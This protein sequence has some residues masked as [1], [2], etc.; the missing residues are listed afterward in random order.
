MIKLQQNPTKEGVNRK[1]NHKKIT[2]L[3]KL[4]VPEVQVVWSTPSE[5]EL[6]YYHRAPYN[7]NK[8]KK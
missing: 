1:E 4:T 2:K 5:S 3:M 7:N 6:D 8:G